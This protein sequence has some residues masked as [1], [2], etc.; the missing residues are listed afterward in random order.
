[1]RLLL[2]APYYD[3]ESVGESWSTYQWVKH[4]SDVHDVTVLTTHFKQWCPEASPTAAKQLIN[5]PEPQLPR[6]FTR[7]ARE[8]KPGYFLF[9]F[10]ARR[11]IKQNRAKLSSFDF[12]HQ[13]NPLAPRYPSPAIGLNIPF[14]IGPIAGA[15]PTPPGF[16]T[17]CVERHWYRHLRSFDQIRLRHDPILYRTFAEAAAVIGVAPYVKEIL[18]AIPLKSFETIAETGPLLLQPWE[19]P[20]H[21][22]SR[23]IRALFVG[24][25]IRTKGVIDAIRAVSI[26]KAQRIHITLDVIGEGDHLSRCQ[27]EV[28]SLQLADRVKFHGRLPRK[29]I[30]YWYKTS[31]VF[32]FPS[33]REPSGNVVFEALSCGLPVITAS[34]GGPGF[35]VDRKCGF[36][37]CPTEP[38]QYQE[39]L[40]QCLILLSQ[41]PNLLASLR[42][43]AHQR[44]R[45]VGMWSTR[46]SKLNELY[47]QISSGFN[48]HDAPKP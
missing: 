32:L 39:Q 35:V 30:D 7:L 45:E 31:D 13:I 5:W 41:S 34:N 42:E 38:A 37:V 10:R 4:L 21:N 6:T 2:I 19:G 20:P 9:L 11:W 1:M 36:T 33:F 12:I 3:K 44:M 46:I 24:R 26:A 22:Q 48:P 14:L 25:V 17:E 43:G 15:I 8:V 27:S 18:K 47:S 29:S 40:A 23:P 28:E 16:R